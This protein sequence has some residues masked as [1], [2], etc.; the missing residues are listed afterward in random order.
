M[1]QV[2]SA[3]GL[4]MSDTTF[5]SSVSLFASFILLLLKL[6]LSFLIAELTLFLS[7]L[8]FSCPNYLRTGKTESAE[9]FLGHLWQKAISQN[10]YLDS[11]LRSLIWLS[12]HLN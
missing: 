1:L 2:C 7:I 11:V 10:F 12:L 4:V 9:I 5:Q 6:T 3:L 8:Y